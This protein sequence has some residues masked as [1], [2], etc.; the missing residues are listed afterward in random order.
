MVLMRK[1]ENVLWSYMW[2]EVKALK[3]IGYGKRQA[4]A[5][6]S[7]FLPQHGP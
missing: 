5:E 4:G 1:P 3:E 2:I 7:G 6:H